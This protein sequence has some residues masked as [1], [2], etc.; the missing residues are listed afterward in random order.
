V[1]GVVLLVLGVWGLVTGADD[2][3]GLF[4][5]NLTQN[6]LHILAGAFGIYGGTKGRGQGYNAT[7]GWIGTVLGTLGFIP[8]MDI[9]LTNLLNS[10]TGITVLHLAIGVVSLLVYYCIKE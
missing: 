1:L 5:V 10:N 4:G 7:I 8:G 6:I 9:L 3:E 2:L